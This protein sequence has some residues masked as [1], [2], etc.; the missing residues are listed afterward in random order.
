[1]ECEPI[2]WMRGIPPDEGVAARNDRKTPNEKKLKYIKKI[3][4][5]LI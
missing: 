3:R 4:Y 5:I 2:K 1:M